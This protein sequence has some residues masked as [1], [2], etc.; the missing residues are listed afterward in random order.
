MNILNEITLYAVSGVF[1]VSAL[2]LGWVTFRLAKSWP[3]SIL[4]RALAPVAM[5]IICPTIL[6]CLYFSLFFAV[7][8]C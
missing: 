1:L 8:R 7:A 4:R 2:A 3:K 5:T 6:V